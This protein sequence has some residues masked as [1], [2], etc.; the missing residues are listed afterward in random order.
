MDRFITYEELERWGFIL[1]SGAPLDIQAQKRLCEAV[2]NQRS[3]LYAKEE[4]LK[5]ALEELGEE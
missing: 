4:Q 2:F 3:K 5:R 1:H